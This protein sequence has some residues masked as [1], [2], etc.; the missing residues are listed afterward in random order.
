MKV[1][2]ALFR[3]I[4]FWRSAGPD[5]LRDEALPGGVVDHGDQTET[6][7]ERVDHPQLDHAGERQDADRQRQNGVGRLR[8]DQD[9]PLVEAVG[10][11][12]APAGPA[13][14]SEGT[15]GPVVIPSASPLCV[16]RRTSQTWATDC[17]HVPVVETI[18]PKKYRR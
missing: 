14:G 8:E 17:I 2:T 11:Q 15:A 12:A 6:E 10:D 13:A 7:R 18:C 9:L 1:K 3:L 4:P 16:S 5:H